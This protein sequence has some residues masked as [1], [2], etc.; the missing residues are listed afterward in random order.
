MIENERTKG[1][2]LGFMLLK[3]NKK[4]VLQVLGHPKVCNTS[5]SFFGWLKVQIT[6]QRVHDQIVV[7]PLG[8]AFFNHLLLGCR[9]FS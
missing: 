7:V 9:S 1:N 6:I 2:H 4:E 8:S 3:S 5:F